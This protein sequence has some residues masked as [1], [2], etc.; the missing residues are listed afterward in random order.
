ML[1]FCAV[2]CI[3]PGSFISFDERHFPPSN[4]YFGG[5]LSNAMLFQTDQNVQLCQITA[6]RELW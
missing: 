1:R 6:D 2:L 4:F 3:F 5:N